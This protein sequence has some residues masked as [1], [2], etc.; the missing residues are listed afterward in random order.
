MIFPNAPKVVEDA[1]TFAGNA[2][3]KAVEL[4]KWLA[5]GTFNIST[6]NISDSEL[7]VWPTIPGWKWTRWTARPACI[8]RG[9]PR[10]TKRDEFAG[11]APDADNNAKLLRLLKDVP[12]EKRTARF[13]CVI[14]LVPCT[15]EKSRARRR[16]VM[17]T[18]L[19]RRFST[20]RAKGGSFLQPAGTERVWLR[21]AVRAGRF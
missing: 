10:W 14:A 5:G 2:A 12:L 20:A 17:R 6:F 4:A 16:S 11:N 15:E 3:K 9:L 1:D 19:K 8:P 21:S 7:C 13:R 18:N